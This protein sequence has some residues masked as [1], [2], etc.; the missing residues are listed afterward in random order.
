MKGF[1]SQGFGI[2]AELKQK[3]TKDE[4]L[5]IRG[6]KGCPSHRAQC[7]GM[8]LWFLPWVKKH[9]L[10]ILESGRAVEAYQDFIWL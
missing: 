2:S 9:L 8:H 3:P 4:N 10:K 6:C 7:G 1:P 5:R